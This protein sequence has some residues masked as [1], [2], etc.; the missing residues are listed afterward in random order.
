VR[1]HELARH[2]RDDQFLLT[3]WSRTGSSPASGTSNSTGQFTLTMDTTVTWLWSTSF[4]FNS[5]AGAGG[6]VNQ[7][8]RWA[9]QGSN[10]TITATPSNYYDFDT[11]TGDAPV[12]Q[13]TNTAITLTMDGPRQVTATFA[14]RL[15]T[16]DVP[17]WWLASHGWTSD[18]DD[19]ALGDQDGDTMFTWRNTWRTPSRPTNC[20]SS[21]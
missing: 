2:G 20:P 13:E 3:G 5:G 15:A 4:W 11:W 8:D 19:A 21:R 1:E 7:A 12:G 17:E 9:A 6:S 10:I 14:A 16:N 18:F